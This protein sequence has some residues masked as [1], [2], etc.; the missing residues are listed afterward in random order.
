MS[1]VPATPFGHPHG[2]R[3]TRRFPDDPETLF[4]A[5]TDPEALR[6]WWGP[7]GFRID[8]IAFSAR[9]GEIYRVRLTEPDGSR[10]AHEGRVLEV[11]RPHR[12]T[13]TWQWTEGPLSRDE[14]LVELEFT[15]DGRGTVVSVTH[16]RFASD[17]E[18]EAHATGWTDTYERVGAWLVTRREG[19]TSAPD[20]AGDQDRPPRT[21][22]P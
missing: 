4:A 6:Q 9:V 18:C 8:A 1:R 12:L 16:S 13:Y 19:R 22:S 21:N 10:W 3:L 11:E 20:P 2:V 17:T 5:F 15:P 7:Y 14:T